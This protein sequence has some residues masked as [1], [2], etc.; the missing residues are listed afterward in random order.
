MNIADLGL[1]FEIK[2]YTIITRVQN[3]K[4]SKCA[5]YFGFWREYQASEFP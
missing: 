5:H 2:Q 3:R 4:S 1:L